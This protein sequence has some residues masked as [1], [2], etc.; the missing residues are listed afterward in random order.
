MCSCGTAVGAADAASE[1]TEPGGRSYAVTGMTC[2][3]CATKVTRAVEQVDGV[4]DVTVDLE[5]GRL[6]VS[7]D[8]VDGAIHEAVTNA[9]YE[10]S[11]V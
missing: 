6:S 9:G 10:I 1:H 7:G 11:K 4:T 3:P 5:T 8:V 2:Q